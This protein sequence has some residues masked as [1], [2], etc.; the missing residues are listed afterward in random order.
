MTAAKSAMAVHAAYIA[1]KCEDRTY[2]DLS[3]VE[4]TTFL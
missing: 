1:V 2:A 3:N 4:K